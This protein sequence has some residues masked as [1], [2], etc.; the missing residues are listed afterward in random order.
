[1]QLASNPQTGKG[2]VAGIVSLDMPISQTGPFRSMVEKL[3]VL[4]EYRNMGVAKR[5][6]TKLEEVALGAGRPLIL[7][8]TVTGS[9][10]ELVYPK[11]GYTFVGVI[12]DYGIS[13]KDGSL[14]GATLFYMDLRRG[15]Q[16]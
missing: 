6:M 10:A 15:N 5:L 7:L 4:P 2:V 11:L 8:D 1:M 12:P 9:P 3:L 14:G 13:P 16:E